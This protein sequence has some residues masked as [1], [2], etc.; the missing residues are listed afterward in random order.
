MYAVVGCTDCENL[1]LL[2]DPHAAETATCPRCGRTHRTKKLRRFVEEESREAA[3]QAR[4]ALLAKQ[5][6]NSEAYRAIRRMSSIPQKKF[7]RLIPVNAATLV[8]KS[9]HVFCSTAATIPI[10]MATMTAMVNAVNARNALAG[11]RWAMSVATGSPNRSDRP[12]SP[13]RTPAIQSMYLMYTGWLSPSCWRSTSTCSWL[14][15]VPRI[16]TATSPGRTFT[17]A[18]VM[19]EAPNSVPTRK[20]SRRAA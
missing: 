18:N 8:R 2:T 4:S 14:P 9:F 20:T 19:T 7:G 11:N 6:G 15:L 12:R 10:G 16:I 13:C 1:W 5:G 3:R 17:S